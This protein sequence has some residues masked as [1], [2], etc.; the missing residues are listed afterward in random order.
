MNNINTYVQSPYCF[1]YNTRL[2]PIKK[3]ING[4]ISI[5]PP[6]EIQRF[7]GTNSSPQEWTSIIEES[8]NNANNYGMLFNISFK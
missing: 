8:E 5:I 4:E 1:G 2:T 6:E 7:T 3:E